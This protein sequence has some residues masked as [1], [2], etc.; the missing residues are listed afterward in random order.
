MN[1]P[2]GVRTEVCACGAA[3]VAT[4]PAYHGAKCYACWKL[5]KKASVARRSPEAT[6]R[7][8]R[9]VFNSHLRKDYGITIEQYDAMLAAQGGVCAICKKPRANGHRLHVDHNHTTGEV[10]GLLC[11]TCNSAIGTLKEDPTLFAA[12]LAYLRGGF[13]AA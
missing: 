5:A 7:N 2:A 6:A 12:A 9:R 10:R 13:H 11:V 3:L 8:E 4:R 1:Y